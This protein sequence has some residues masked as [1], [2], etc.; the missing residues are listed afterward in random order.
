MARKGPGLRKAQSGNEY[1][2]SYPNKKETSAVLNGARASTF[3]H[4][5]DESEGRLFFGDNLPLLRSLYDDSSVRGQVDLIYIDPPFATGSNFSSRSQT[6]AYS[7][8]LV[9]AEFIEFLR[10][11]LILLAEL[12]SAEGSIY[13]HLDAR[14][15]FPIKIIMDEIFGEDN[16]R[17]FITR[18]KSNPK[19]YTRLT[20]G[21][22]ADHIL[23]FSKS[24][25]YIWNKQTVPPSATHLKEYR[26]VDKD[27]RRHMRVPLHAPG[28][29]HGE[30]GKVWRGLAP[31]PGKHWQYKP[32]KLDALDK[33]GRI[34]WSATGNPRK[35]VYLDEHAGVSVQDIWLDFKDAHN[36]NIQI[37]GYPTEK[38]PELIERII[39]ASS[40]PR[41]LVLDCFAGSGTTLDVA[42]QLGRRWI[43]F[44][45]SPE[46][47][48][49]IARRMAQGTRPM[50]DFR[51][52]GK[53]TNKTEVSQMQAPRDFVFSVLQS[54]Q[55]ELQAYANERDVDRTALQDLCRKVQASMTNSA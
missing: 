24:D 39:R 36:Q 51:S 17:A 42:G 15:V 44:D 28:I 53:E 26:Y 23:F 45:C 20:Y 9:G 8:D 2:V 3:D 1:T 29:R 47:M 37:T 14:I 31:P 33:E 30:T 11:R 32:E 40:N 27:K 54:R 18:K 34:H 4:H 12:L 25:Q 38:N 55:D 7:D 5:P 19:N 6:H 50:G 21:N 48:A 43:G 46:S 35:K 22:V 13:V 16:F 49:T 10:E 41:S 52:Q